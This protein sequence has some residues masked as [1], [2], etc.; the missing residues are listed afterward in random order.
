MTGPMSQV[1]CAIA[2]GDR[3]VGEVRAP[4]AAERPAGRGEHQPRRP[5][6]GCRPAGTGRWPSARSRPARSGPAWPRASTSGPPAISDSLFASAS[7][8]PVASARSVGSR[9]REPVMALS[10]M[11]A[12]VASISSATASGPARMRG[13]RELAP[14]VAAP[15]GL[16]V[17]RELRRP[18]PRSSGTR[19]PRG[20]RWP[21]AWAARAAGSAP[22]AATPTTSNR[23][24]L[25][26]TT[27]MAWTPTE[28]VEPSTRTLRLVIAPILQY[29]L[30]GIKS[31][32]RLGLV[33]SRLVRT[34]GWVASRSPWVRLAAPWVWW[35]LGCGWSSW[36]V[37]GPFGGVGACAGRI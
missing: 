25:A 36:V 20:H 13:H 31:V 11:S 17:E 14:L 22:P 34:G 28:P 37:R 7:V 10:T 9:P 21:A 16:G 29:R 2:C 1:G 35:L 3:D 32:G 26:A 6:R 24:G 19:P 8:A 30:S 23:S 18:R 5:R 12:R 27:S 15:L 33:P 4:P